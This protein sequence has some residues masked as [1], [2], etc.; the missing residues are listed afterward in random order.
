MKTEEYLIL[1]LA[2][3][4]GWIVRTIMS[5]RNLI[6]GA[7]SVI[8][9]KEIKRTWGEPGTCKNTCKNLI[10]PDGKLAC[11]QGGTGICDPSATYIQTNGGCSKTK[12]AGQYCCQNNCY[13]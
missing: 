5:E 4:M 12:P 8:D 9:A 1:G 3:V 2:C 6:E 10:R 11:G 7:R 13:G